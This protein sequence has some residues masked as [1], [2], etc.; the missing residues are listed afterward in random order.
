MLDKLK[1]RV[2]RAI[3][4]SLATS[5]ELLVH[6]R[7]IA[8]LSLFYWY[9]FGRCSSEL[10]ELGTLPYSRGRFT[11]YSDMYVCVCVKFI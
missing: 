3:G 8:S 6:R 7:N 4:P 9:Y 1:E 2:Y 5:F 11:C 10:A